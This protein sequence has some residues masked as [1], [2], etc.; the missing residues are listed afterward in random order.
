MS[1]DEGAATDAWK[2]MQAESVPNVYILEGGINQWISIF[3]ATDASIL[4]IEGSVPD[5]QLRYTFGAALGDRYEACSPAPYEWNL[6]YTPKIELKLQRSP[7]GG[8]CG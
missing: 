6:D 1:N 7:S 5:D 2:I 4:P 8:G 3:G